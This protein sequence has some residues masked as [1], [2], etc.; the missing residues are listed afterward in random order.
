MLVVLEG[1]DGAGKTT[2]ADGLEELLL[3]DDPGS[4]VMRLKAGPPRRHPLN[5]YLRPLCQYT[6]GSRQHWILDRWHWG[7]YVYPLAR[8]RTSQLD[9]PAWW[10]IE[11]Y[12]RRLGAVVV[13]VSQY[14][15][16]Y[17]QVYRDR[18]ES[19]D[20]VAELPL[21][22]K[23]YR[24]AR[25][26]SQLPVVDFNWESGVNGDMFQII[27]RAKLVEVARR[28]L[29]HVRTYLGP[30][31]PDVLLL[32]DVRH[33]LGRDVPIELNY[34]PAF[35]PFPGTSGHYLLSS[36]FLAE[37]SRIRSGA[38]LGIANACDVDDPVQLWNVLGRPSVVTLGRNAERRWRRLTVLADAVHA[39]TATVP[40]P[41][42]VRRFHHSMKAG[43]GMLIWATAAYGGD[44]G[45][46]PLSSKQLPAARRTSRSSK[47]SG[48]AVT[49][50][51]VVMAP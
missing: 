51:P 13:Q 9:P 3:R 33:N 22:D 45:S 15:D 42:Y 35:V 20:Q 27:D 46:W 47:R 10:A 32:G 41:Q 43:Y 2:L 24:E 23:L 39:S 38:K 16:R 50:V 21:V 29:D 19:E 11:A 1:P 26:M 7:E 36:L 8:G 14:P 5:E 17:R 30:L 44:N 40:H 12:L 4:C 34:D 28:G 25:A 48:A 31:Q 49:S 6:P 37:S 18:G